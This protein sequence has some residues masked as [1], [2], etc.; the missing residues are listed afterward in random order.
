MF[1]PESDAKPVWTCET[2]CFVRVPQKQKI[3]QRLLGETVCE[4]NI[5]LY[6][7]HQLFPLCSGH[8]SLQSS[9]VQFNLFNMHI[10]TF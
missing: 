6:G 7:V 9:L 3:Q 4:I 1:L 5:G 10:F 2:I 8:N